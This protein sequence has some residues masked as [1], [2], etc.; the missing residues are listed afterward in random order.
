M[1]QRSKPHVQISFQ[2]GSDDEGAAAVLP[3]AAERG[4][5]AHSLHCVSLLSAVQIL[6]LRTI[7]PA[8]KQVG[9]TVH[10]PSRN[11]APETQM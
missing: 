2:T 6:P 7:R 10:Y 11:K 4:A 1:V 8:T 9:F 3:P 5:S